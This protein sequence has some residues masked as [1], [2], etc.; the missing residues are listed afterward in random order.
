MQVL[1]A[2]NS[3]TITERLAW[4][5]GFTFTCPSGGEEYILVAQN[6]MFTCSKI[7]KLR[8]LFL[9]ITFST[10]FSGSLPNEAGNPKE[11]LGFC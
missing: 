11:S 1:H 3:D 9:V 6:K 10:C 8:I 4:H 5:L 2:I 7:E